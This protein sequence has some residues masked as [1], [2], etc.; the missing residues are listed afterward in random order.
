MVFFSKK[1]K[2]GARR[3]YLWHELPGP[4]LEPALAVD[5]RITAIGKLGRTFT[6]RPALDEGACSR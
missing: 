4:G 1:K 6:C 5:L 3:P 2:I